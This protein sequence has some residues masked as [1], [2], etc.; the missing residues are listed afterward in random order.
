MQIVS[1]FVQRYFEP[2]DLQRFKF[3]VSEDVRGGGLEEA[4][5]GGKMAP[6]EACR[7]MRQA[8]LG[9]AAMHAAG[10]AHGDI[11]PANVA[12]ETYGSQPTNV[13]LLYDAAELPSALDL[14]QLQE[15]SRVALVA[16]YLAPELLAAGRSPDALSDI[17]GLGAVLYALLAGKPPFA[18]GDVQQK[19]KRQL[20]EPARPL[21]TMGV[22][23]PLAQLVS[24]LMAKNPEMRYRSA[25]QVADQLALFVPPV[26]LSSAPP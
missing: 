25:A 17:Y 15:G 1:P 24:Y 19:L 14:S 8:A 18:G 13:K 16:D 2:V 26:G 11:R 22:P 12:L 20:S 6:A 5:A 21:E 23:Q 3:I 10:R 7:L 4:L 9:L